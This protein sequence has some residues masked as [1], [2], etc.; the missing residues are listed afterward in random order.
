MRRPRLPFPL[1]SCSVNFCAPSRVAFT[2]SSVP[3]TSRL[4][5]LEVSRLVLSRTPFAFFIIPGTCLFN[6]AIRVF[7]SRVETVR[8][9]VMVST[10]WR[11]AARAGSARSAFTLVR[12]ESSLGSIF[13]TTGIISAA[14][15]IIPEFTIPGMMPPGSIRS[16]GLLASRRLTWRLPMISLEISAVLPA[17]ILRSLLISTL[18]LMGPFPE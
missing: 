7:S 1:F 13:S 5:R 8:L 3:C 10:L 12:M 2:R 9:L 15:P 18:T 16:R 4:A 6:P 17:G 14:L 11:E